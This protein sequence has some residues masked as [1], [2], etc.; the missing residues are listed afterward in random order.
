MVACACGALAIAVYGKLTILERAFAPE[1]ARARRLIGEE[2][3]CCL[4][5]LEVRAHARRLRARTFEPRACPEPDIHCRAQDWIDCMTATFT[6]GY[7]PAY[8]KDG[9]GVAHTAETILFCGGNNAAFGSEVGIAAIPF[10]G[11]VVMLDAN[12]CGHAAC[13]SMDDAVLKGTYAEFGVACKEGVSIAHLRR[14]EE[15]RVD[16]EEAA[17]WAHSFVTIAERKKGRAHPDAASLKRWP[18]LDAVREERV[19]A[20]VVEEEEEEEEGVGERESERAREPASK[21]ARESTD[22]PRQ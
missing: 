9:K 6:S 4:P 14:L 11:C 1:T 17:E 13:L 3:T 16:P 5:G 22:T 15:L 12:E 18:W 8:H 7:A 21:R 10:G 19:E 20:R 2:F